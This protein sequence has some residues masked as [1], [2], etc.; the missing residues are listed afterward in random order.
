VGSVQSIYSKAVNL[1]H[2]SGILISIVNSRE[3][4]TEY[5]ILLNNFSS[6]LSCITIGSKF[7]WENNIGVFSGVI[8][9]IGKTSVWNGTPVILI[10]NS[11][12]DIP[13]LKKIFIQFTAED[14]L[15]PII[16]G[17]N[18]NIYSISAE[19]ILKNAFLLADLS[20]DKL[21]DLSS[22]IG[23]GIG[24][25]P[26]GDDFIT[27]VLLYEF[28]TGIKLIDRTRIQNGLFK[29]TAGSRTLLLLA[30]RN[31]F[32]FYL[33]Q[34]AESIFSDSSSYIELVGKV[35]SHG[36]TSGSDSLT[37]FLWAAEKN[38]KNIQIKLT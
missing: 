21:I 37:G 36:S 15:S 11:P 12:I 4:M 7:S 10:D 34:F 6:F 14:G 18:G 27:G 13:H 19:K 3:Q 5:G 20:N 32:P 9:D 26:S 25:T 28:L 1:V 23:M 38:E 16:T 17:K 30:L 22:I 29:T 33:K 8:L 31:S 2:P 24:F 35:V